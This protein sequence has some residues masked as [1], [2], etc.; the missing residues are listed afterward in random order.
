MPNKRYLTEWVQRLPGL[1]INTLLLEYEDKFPYRAYPFL[2]DP[3][4]FTETELHNFLSAAR[5][6]GLHIIPLVQ[7][8][9][10]L[11]FALAHAELA[12]L[13]EAPDIPTQICPRNPQAVAFV[14][15][16]IREV[17]A[18]HQT[19]SMFHLGGD[20]ACHL[21]ACPTCKT[22]LQERG[23]IQSW[24]EHEGH[25]ARMLLQAGK[26]PLLWDDV[27]WKEPNTLATVALPKET[28]L[29]AWDYAL[30]PQ[31]AAARRREQ[32]DVEIL[33]RVDIYTRLGYRAIGAPCCNWGVLVPQHS[34]TLGNT[35][36]MAE[37]IR[38]ADQAGLI[39]TTWAC[40]HVPLPVGLLQ[41]AATGRLCPGKTITP[42]WE[43]E[44]WQKEFGVAVPGISEALESLG[45]LWEIPV[46]LDRPLTMVP[47]GYMDMVLHYGS[48]AERWKAGAYPLDFQTID[49]DG[50]YRR[51]LAILREKADVAGV[52]SRA[53]ELAE[54]YRRALE[55]LAPLEHATHRH[56]EARLWLALARF[57]LLAVRVLLHHLTG[58]EPGNLDEPITGLRAALVPFL[59]P[60]SVEKLMRLWAQP[61]RASLHP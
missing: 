25:F 46:G 13:R 39:N 26:T 58:A 9:S 24:V 54:R 7:T 10:H 55:V 59:E 40:F 57:K 34:H 2:R 43:E 14:E 36:V 16:L 5:A 30:T 20:E 52:I 44:F 28:V 35:Q 48:Q 32:P 8:C 47:Y 22:W 17:L 60:R 61:L 27:F 3:E 21:G 12:N 15:T 6:A 29:V 33:E 31:K 18:F 56:D 45:E 38:A 19:D 23:R 41:V 4:G 51:K 11:E 53:R 49:V 37:K 50:L 42:A 1:G